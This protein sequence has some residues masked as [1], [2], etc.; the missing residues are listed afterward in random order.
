MKNGTCAPT[1]VQFCYTTCGPEKIGVKSE[2]CQTSGTYAE[3]SG[4]SF[5]PGREYACYKI[6]TTANAACP[7][8][9]TPQ[10]L[11]DC[12]VPICTL[13]NDLGGRSAGAYFDGT[14]FKV[15]YCVCQPP[16]AFGRRTWSCASDTAW[17]CRAGC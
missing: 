16:N 2:T 1:D 13:C 5:D 8:G 7:A 14:T 17:P 15:G 6:P 3:M 12:D 9:A 4:C 10:P 11:Q